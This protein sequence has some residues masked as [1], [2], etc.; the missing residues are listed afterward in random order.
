MKPGG[1]EEDVVVGAAAG[2]DNSDDKESLNPGGGEDV[3][4]GAAD[5]SDDKES[6]NPGGGDVDDAVVA[7]H[8]LTD[9]LRCCGP[10]I[11]YDPCWDN[12]RK[13]VPRYCCCC[14]CRCCWG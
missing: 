14:C 2:A 4:A 9:A 7:A 1:G 5:N 11:E 8:V 3:G 6:S 10:G 12:R 13:G